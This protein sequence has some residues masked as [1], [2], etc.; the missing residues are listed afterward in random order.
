MGGSFVTLSPV[1]LSLQVL[2]KSAM[3]IGHAQRCCTCVSYCSRCRY[4]YTSCFQS[5]RHN[6]A[7]DLKKA[8]RCCAF[9][10]DLSVCKAAP[11]LLLTAYMAIIMM[12]RKVNPIGDFGDATT[13]SHSGDGALI[14]LNA[15]WRMLDTI[16]ML[17][18]S[19]TSP[20][21]ISWVRVT[22]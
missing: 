16:N 11:D 14:S 2:A 9:L 5:S 21:L 12:Q 22:F 10:K 17:M 7:S 13:S 4:T 19:F 20:W 15:S 6:A 1:V 18:E 3:T 8:R